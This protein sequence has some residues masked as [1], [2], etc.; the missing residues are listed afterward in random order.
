MGARCARVW[1]KDSPA[2]G[3][4][5]GTRYPQWSL[6]TLLMLPGL[7]EEP[8][9]HPQPRLFAPLSLNTGP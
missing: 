9:E 8:Q 7:L 4:P 3:I 6:S 1:E 5:P 2:G